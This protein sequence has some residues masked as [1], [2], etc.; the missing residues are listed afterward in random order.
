M[1]RRADMLDANGNLYV[2]KRR[3]PIDQFQRVLD[4]FGPNSISQAYHCEHILRGRDGYFYLVDK[5]DDAQ[6]VY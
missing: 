5:V 3:F 2:I 6:I 4:T 1:Y